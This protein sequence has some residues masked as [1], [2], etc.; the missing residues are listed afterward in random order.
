MSQKQY[1]N[2]RDSNEKEIIKHIEDF[3]ATVIQLDKFDLA[4][5]YKGV[6]HLMEVKNPDQDW[7][8]TPSQRKIMNNWKGS[9]LHIITSG[10]MA[11]NLLERLS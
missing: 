8:I 3:G 10:D 9:P 4:V 11:I 2:K 6:T 1:A 5:G 7:S